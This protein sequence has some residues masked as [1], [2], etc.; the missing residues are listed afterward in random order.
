MD[1]VASVRKSTQVVRAARLDEETGEQEARDGDFNTALA[2]E[3]SGG[4]CSGVK[5]LR[6]QAKV[7]SAWE[8]NSN[9]MGKRQHSEAQHEHQ[10][11][12][13]CF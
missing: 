10:K 13:S 12:C 3:A 1:I 11:H 2:A 8:C 5:R 4:L 9:G 7:N 6:R